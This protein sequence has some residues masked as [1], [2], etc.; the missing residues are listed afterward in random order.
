MGGICEPFEGTPDNSILLLEGDWLPQQMD[1]A[2][3]MRQWEEIEAT[4]EQEARKKALREAYDRQQYAIATRFLDT[5]EHYS[6]FNEQIAANHAKLTAGLQ[7]IE[8]EIHAENQRRHMK[9][10]W[11]YAYLGDNREDTTG[12][13]DRRVPRAPLPPPEPQGVSGVVNIRDIF[14]QWHPHWT[15]TLPP[16]TGQGGRDVG[17]GRM[18][19]G[20]QGG[21]AEM[22]DYSRYLDPDTQRL[23]AEDSRYSRLPPR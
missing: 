9:P 1:L 12:T 15:E 11:P 10:E 8:D 3:Y 5:K 13:E 2:E 19:Q 23:R 16:A 18:Y 20:Y 22:A 14:A 6:T 4:A 21:T 17:Y 7:A